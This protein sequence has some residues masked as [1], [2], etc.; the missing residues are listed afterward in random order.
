[1]TGRSFLKLLGPHQGRKV[2]WHRA[3]QAFS[4]DFPFFLPFSDFG[5]LPK[6]LSLFRGFKLHVAKDVGVTPDEFIADPFSDGFKVKKAALFSDL[7][8]KNHLQQKIPKLF[9]K[10]IRVPKFSS[11]SHLISF[12]EGIGNE[13]FEILFEI[14]GAPCLGIP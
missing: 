5:F 3:Q 7:G 2:L 12:F 8:M 1:M 11:L 13:A 9:S 4:S 6:K 10:I 14:P